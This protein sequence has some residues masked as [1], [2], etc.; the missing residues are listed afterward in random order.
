M[1]FGTLALGAW[2]LTC[3]TTREVLRHGKKEPWY[4][5]TSQMWKQSHHLTANTTEPRGGDSLFQAQ[6]IACDSMAVTQSLSGKQIECVSCDEVQKSLESAVKKEIW[7]LGSQRTLFKLL[8]LLLWSECLCPPSICMFL[9]VIVSGNRASERWLGPEDRALMSG[10]ST[11]R[12]EAAERMLPSTS[13]IWSY[14]KK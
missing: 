12:R 4:P 11:L 9:Q 13:A 14:S 7:A 8:D 2:N 10:I 1:K 5:L 3:W 6:S